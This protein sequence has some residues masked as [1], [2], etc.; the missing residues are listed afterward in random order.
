[1]RASETPE[2]VERKKRGISHS[3]D[4]VRNDGW[5]FFLKL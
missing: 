1:L 3:A 2:T 4:S 5:E